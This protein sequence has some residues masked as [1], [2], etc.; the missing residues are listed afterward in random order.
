[1]APIDTDITQTDLNLKGHL[2][3]TLGPVIA[4]STLTVAESHQRGIILWFSFATETHTV[5]CMRL[6]VAQPPAAD[7]K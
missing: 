5:D 6:P 3:G 7:I 4:S 1:M 2:H